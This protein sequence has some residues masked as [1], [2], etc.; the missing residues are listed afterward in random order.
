VVLSDGGVVSS[1]Q[2]ADLPM[3]LGGQEVSSPAPEQVGQG[4]VNRPERDPGW[5]RYHRTYQA[6]TSPGRVVVGHGAWDWEKW[7][8]HPTYVYVS[9][10][11]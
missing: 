1:E 11:L 4:S 8:G 2:M 7:F 10:I 9:A 6:D 3:G 5:E